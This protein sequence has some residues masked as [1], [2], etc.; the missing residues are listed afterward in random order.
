MSEYEHLLTPQMRELLTTPGV[1]EEMRRI[2]DAMDPTELAR[3]DC[4]RPRQPSDID[5]ARRAVGRPTSSDGLRELEAEI[6]ALYQ[7]EDGHNREIPVGRTDKPNVTYIN[8]KAAHVTIS[9][10]AGKTCVLLAGPITRQPDQTRTLSRTVRLD[11]YYDAD[12]AEFDIVFKVVTRAVADH[13]RVLREGGHER[14][15][16]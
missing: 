16:P 1:G 14:S 4:G 9:K 6:V 15:T 3:I 12:R 8:P 7:I 13:L 11:H 2:L 5:L 10:W